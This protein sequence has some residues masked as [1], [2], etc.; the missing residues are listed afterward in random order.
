MKA[1]K[2]EIDIQPLDAPDEE[3]SYYWRLTGKDSGVYLN[4]GLG[5]SVEDCILR[6]RSSYTQYCITMRE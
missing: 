2:A 6:A 5:K 1:E 3:W 4:G